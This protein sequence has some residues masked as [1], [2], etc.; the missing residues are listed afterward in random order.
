MADRLRMSALGCTVVVVAGLLLAA[1]LMTQTYRVPTA[2]MEP[3]IRIGDT[4]FTWKTRN[5]QRGDIIALDYPLQPGVVFVKRA[6]AVPGDTVEIHD[7]QLFVNGE[8]TEEPYVQHADPQTFPRDP[9]LPE[10]YRSRDQYGPYRIA[11]ENFFVLGDNRDR[12]SD[13]RYWGTLPRRNV[14]GVVTLIFS[15]KRGFVIP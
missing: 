3:T 10:P 2:A 5:P 15:F 6:V 7:K 9:R 14:R 12:S 8:K 1:R 13:S 11:P 4:I